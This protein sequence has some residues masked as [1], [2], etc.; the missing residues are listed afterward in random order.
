MYK[1]RILTIASV[2]LTLLLCLNSASTDEIARLRIH[3]GRLTWGL[4]E[5]V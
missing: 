5:S 2:S 3:S 1:R 4:K